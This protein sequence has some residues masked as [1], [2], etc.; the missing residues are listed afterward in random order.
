MVVFPP[1][2]YELASNLLSVPNKKVSAVPG[3]FARNIEE[4]TKQ[5]G[6][7]S[8]KING[9]GTTMFSKESQPKLRSR[10]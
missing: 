2:R 1:E 7:Y 4:K 6:S 5:N 3:D 10:N 9:V 8:E